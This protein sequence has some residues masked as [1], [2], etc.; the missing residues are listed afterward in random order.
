[1]PQTP[2]PLRFP[3]GKTSIW[4][5]ISK[6]VKDN[7]LER[8]HYVEPYAGGCGLALSLMF[9]GYV[10]ELHLKRYRSFYFRVLGND[11]LSYRTVHCKNTRNTYY[12]GRV[13]Q[14]A[15]NSKK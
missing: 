7:G 5:M 4:R 13:V 3:G 8:G 9:G 2:S 11:H 14:A 6:I 1:M 10:H 12:N 15:F